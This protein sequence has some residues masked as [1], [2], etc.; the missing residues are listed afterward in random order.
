MPTPTNTCEHLLCARQNQVDPLFLQYLALCILAGYPT[1]LLP[2]R[3]SMAL[4]FVKPMGLL[5]LLFFFVCFWTGLMYRRLAL[6]TEDATT[7][8]A[9]IAGLVYAVLG[10]NPCFPTC[11]ANCAA[12]ANNSSPPSLDA[13]D[14]SLML[15][16]TVFFFNF[17]GL[18]FD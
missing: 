14:Q 3:F 18:P 1:P 16:D 8:R 13:V 4:T 11:Q 12:L 5:E 6:K 10:M 17:S 2:T 7:A 15:L 9:W